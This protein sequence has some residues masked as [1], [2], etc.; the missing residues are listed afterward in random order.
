MTWKCSRVSHAALSTQRE[1]TGTPGDLGGVR[2]PGCTGDRILPS[3]MSNSFVAARQQVTLKRAHSSWNTALS[4]PETPGWAGI[5][6]A[7]PHCLQKAIM[8]SPS[9]VENKNHAVT[10]FIAS[11]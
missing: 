10:C 1:Y 4:Y 6:A 3:R 5:P 8:G 9:P 2:T 7:E 11:S